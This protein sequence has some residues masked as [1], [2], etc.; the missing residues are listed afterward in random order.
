VQKTNEKKRKFAQTQW[1]SNRD[2][3]GHTYL[4]N[5]VLRPLIHIPI[6]V[7]RGSTVAM[8]AAHNFKL[9]YATVFYRKQ[10]IFPS[11]ANE[12]CKMFSRI[13]QHL[14]YRLVRISQLRNIC[15]YSRWYRRRNGYGKKPERVYVIFDDHI[16]VRDTI[17]Y[18]PPPPPPTTATTGHKQP[19]WSSV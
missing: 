18:T 9:I 11:T 15:N 19:E 6:S 4:I 14:L 17:P 3:P 16:Y 5:W 12:K 8:M 13:M 2:R 7:C 1:T 10:H